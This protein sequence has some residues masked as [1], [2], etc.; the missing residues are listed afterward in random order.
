MTMP[1]MKPSRGLPEGVSFWHP[2]TLAVTWFGTG[3][4]PKMPGTWGSL[5]TLPVAWVLAQR[6]GP[7][8][9]AAAAVI[10]F[11][12]GLWACRVYLARSRTKDPGEIVIDEVAGQLLAVAPAGLD[13]LAFGLAFVL[14]RIFDTM[15]PW[16]LRNL[17]QL[18]GALG[19]MAD[20]IGAGLYTAIMISLY[21]L[22]LGKPGVFF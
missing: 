9:V 1:T 7:Y 16:P 5:A 22:I 2:A 4:L 15:K 10:A 13:P 6:F 21:F 18:R 14:F 11:V 19:V 17:E 12:I 8:A 3:L 20:D